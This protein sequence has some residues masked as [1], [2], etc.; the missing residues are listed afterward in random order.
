M[1]TELTLEV[2]DKF[3]VNLLR[4]QLLNAINSVTQ[5]R[6]AATKCKVMLPSSATKCCQ[7]QRSPKGVQ[8][9]IHAG[10]VRLG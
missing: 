9:L 3:Q 1:A 7:L 10:D 2:R 5:Q 8:N 4:C 6:H